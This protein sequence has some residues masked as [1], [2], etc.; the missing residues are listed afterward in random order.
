MSRTG[1]MTTVI[2]TRIAE[3][4]AKDEQNEGCDLSAGLFG[5]ELSAVVRELAQELT[6]AQQ[7]STELENAI[8]SNLYDAP[9]STGVDRLLKLANQNKAINQ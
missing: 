4:V 6:Q 3:A 2:A 9:P 8:L 7:R 5:V 1:M